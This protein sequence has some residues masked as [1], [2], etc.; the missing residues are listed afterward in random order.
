[1]EIK[2]VNQSTAQIIVDR[3]LYSSE[4]VHKCFYWYGDK[5]SV[6]IKIEEEFF[7]IVISEISNN[8]NIEEIFPKIKNDLVDFKTREI[9]L[10]ETKNIREILIAKAFAFGDDLDELPPGNLNDPIGFDPFE[11]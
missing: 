11:F 3:K 5:Y 4:V 9:V 6:D 8:G 2:V 7:V 10:T 1:M